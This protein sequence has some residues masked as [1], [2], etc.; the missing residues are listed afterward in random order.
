LCCD[1]YVIDP[2]YGEKTIS[3]EN[4]LEKYKWFKKHDNPKYT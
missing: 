4:A 1:Y 2:F 3:K